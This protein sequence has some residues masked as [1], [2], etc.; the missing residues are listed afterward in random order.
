MYSLSD[1]KGS[2][3]ANDQIDALFCV[4]IYYTCL[5]VSSITVLII[6]ISNCINTSFGMMGQPRGLV[7]RASDY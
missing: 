5:R 2:F 6:R 1:I 7:V 3:F 4:F